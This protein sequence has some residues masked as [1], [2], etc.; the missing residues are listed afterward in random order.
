MRL[1][2]KAMFQDFGS[3]HYELAKLYDLITK[4]NPA[5]LNLIQLLC[6]K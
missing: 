6:K 3:G 1:L 5:R 4:Q 2:K